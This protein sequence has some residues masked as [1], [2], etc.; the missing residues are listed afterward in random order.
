MALAH[1][2]AAHAA[3]AG[4]P[5]LGSRIVLQMQGL[6]WIDLDQPEAPDLDRLAAEY[7]FHELAVEDCRNHPQLA[8]ID[9]FADHLFLI[10]NSISFDPAERE[11][12]V[13]EIDF[14]LGRNYLVTVHDGPSRSVDQV[15]ARV[16]GDNRIRKPADI[17]Y[18]VL[19]SILDRFL[20]T[21]DEIGDTIDEIEDKV[22][23]VPDAACLEKIFRLKRNL[24]SFRRAAAAQR[25]LLNVLSR[26]DSEFVPENLVIYFR[27]VYDHVVAT[28]EM[29]ESYRDLLSGILEIYL[30]QTANRTND[31][32]KA[33]TLISTIILPLTLVVGWYGMNF[34][35]LPF[36]SDP[37]GVWYVSAAMV[38]FAAVLLGYFRKRGWI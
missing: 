24:V 36:A 14:F 29:I 2:P 7:G 18:Y 17:L 19:D 8:K 33:L 15:V 4:A 35:R 38:L 22:L 21:L 25:E 9:P 30:T 1:P 27:D 13:R 37:N 5:P 23:G 3:G 6:T 34:E 11:L 32:V 28:M 31:I 12:T 20:P 26:R 10:A 16:T